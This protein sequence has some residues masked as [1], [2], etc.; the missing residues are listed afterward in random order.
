MYPL[1]RPSLKQLDFSKAD[2]PNYGQEVPGTC[3]ASLLATYR[4]RSTP[5]VVPS[6][7]LAEQ[8]TV[9]IVDGGASY[10]R[11]PVGYL[12]LIHI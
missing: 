3:D 4:T 11:V 7:V 2:S 5:T 6:V 1:P 10:S 8:T 12:S 9:E